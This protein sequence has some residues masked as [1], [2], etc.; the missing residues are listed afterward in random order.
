MDNLASKDKKIK[1]KLFN[2]AGKAIKLHRMHYMKSCL[3]PQ[4]VYR[5]GPAGRL[6]QLVL[7]YLYLN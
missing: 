4:I 5:V 1:I 6:Q 7:Y 3:G 2:L